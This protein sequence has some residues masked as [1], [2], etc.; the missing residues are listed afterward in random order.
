ML[1]PRNY[2]EDCLRYGL[3]DLWTT[4]FPFNVVNGAID[5]RF[6]YTVPDAAKDSWTKST[7]LHWEN[8]SDS[9]TKDVRCPRCGTMMKVPWTTCGLPEDSSNAV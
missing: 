2:L 9:M 3:K 4:G 7:G 5:I 6:N 1:N 8:A